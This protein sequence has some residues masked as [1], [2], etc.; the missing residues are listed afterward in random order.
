MILWLSRLPQWREVR[1]FTV[2]TS[3]LGVDDDGVDD[4]DDDCEAAVRRR[5]TRKVK[6]IPSYTATYKL[7][8]KGRWMSVSRIK[9]DQKWGWQEKSTLHITYV[10]YVPFFSGS[11][12]ANL[13]GLDPYSMFARKRAALDALIEEARELYMA[14]RN[15]KIDIYASSAG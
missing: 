11:Y 3:S 2:S 13:L 15:D 12:A 14:S 5:K 6:C 10:S 8:Y 7:W 9:D 4:D 1:E